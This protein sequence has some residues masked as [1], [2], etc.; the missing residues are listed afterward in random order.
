[1]KKQEVKEVTCCDVCGDEVWFDEERPTA[2]CKCGR[3][4]CEAC[5]TTVRV[6]PSQHQRCND[7]DP[8]ACGLWRELGL[9]PDCAARLRAWLD[10]D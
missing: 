6:M 4:V 8:N 10:E 2:K 1:M 7:L 3:D 9:C 5:A